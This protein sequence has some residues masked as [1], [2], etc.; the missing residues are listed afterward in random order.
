MCATH[1]AGS[2]GDSLPLPCH[3]R[4][5]GTA[6]AAVG[7]RVSNDVGRS[8]GP[9]APNTCAQAGSD[10]SGRPRQPTCTAYTAKSATCQLH[11]THMHYPHHLHTQHMH[12]PHHSRVTK[13]RRPHS[14]PEA[15]HTEG[16][17][18]PAP[19]HFTTFPLPQPTDAELT[20]CAPPP[21][22][23]PLIRPSLA[24]YP[25]PLI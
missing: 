20:T 9:C 14:A 15:A 17:S 24:I 21:P 18:M 16:A 11:H 23:H 8:P 10:T 12:H 5:A 1:A 22:S 3:T 2:Y 6:A 25:D 4:T 7:T 13:P 19:S